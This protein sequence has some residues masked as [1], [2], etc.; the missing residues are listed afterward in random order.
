MVTTSL[1]ERV[2]VMGV[3]VVGV[4]LLIVRALAEHVTEVPRPNY[5]GRHFHE[6]VCS[7]RTLAPTFIH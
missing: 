1:V 7:R 4:V 5:W 3:R 2:A 6:I